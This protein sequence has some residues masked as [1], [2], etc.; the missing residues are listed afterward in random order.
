MGRAD[1]RRTGCIYGRE[2]PDFAQNARACA[3]K[4]AAEGPHKGRFA[5]FSGNSAERAAMRRIWGK[6]GGRGRRNAHGPKG[7][8]PKHGTDSGGGKRPGAPGFSLSW[9]DPLTRRD[10][11][12]L[13]HFLSYGKETLSLVDRM[14]IIYIIESA[15]WNVD[16]V[17]DIK[18]KRHCGNTPRYNLYLCLYI[19]YKDI[20]EKPYAFCDASPLPFHLVFST[21]AQYTYCIY[22]LYLVIARYLIFRY[23]GC[24]HIIYIYAVFLDA[25]EFEKSFGCHKEGN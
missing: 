2:N 16:C 3:Y 1:I 13:D 5:G 7:G 10:G 20:K 9:G 21:R 18:Y 15:D 23:M 19:I 25:S 17:L 4:E 11:A 22:T 8:N 24:M 6:T 14:Y 12:F